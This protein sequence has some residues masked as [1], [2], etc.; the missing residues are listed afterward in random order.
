MSGV[1]VN[2]LTSYPKCTISVERAGSDELFRRFVL[3]TGARAT[4][5]KQPFGVCPVKST[6]AGDVVPVDYFGPALVEAGAAI[7]LA[8]GMKAI[9]PDAQGRA[10]AHAGAVPAA[11]FAL[12]A[13]S[14]AGDIVLAI[15]IPI[16]A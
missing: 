13:A 9:M 6:T 10:V 7:A 15:I 12:Q 14:A 8:D 2:N 16:P 4:A 3:A 11:G 5:G 1:V